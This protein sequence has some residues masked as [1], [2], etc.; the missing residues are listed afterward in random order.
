MRDGWVNMT[1]GELGPFYGDCIREGVVVN[2]R[3]S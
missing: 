2:K 1:V 3:N